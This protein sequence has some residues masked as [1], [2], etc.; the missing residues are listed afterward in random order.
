MRCAQGRITRGEIVPTGNV[1]TTCIDMITDR[2]Q[3]RVPDKNPR[4]RKARKS[5]P[6]SLVN[7]SENSATTFVTI[8]LP[9]PL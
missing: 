2:R 3:T 5:N 6:N 7:Y 4:V 9:R 1:G 8:F